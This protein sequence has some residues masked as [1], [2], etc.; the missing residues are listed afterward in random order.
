[1]QLEGKMSQIQAR[2]VHSL[3]IELADKQK[4]FI[5]IV[6]KDFAEC[7]MPSLQQQKEKKDSHLLY[8]RI[9]Q[10][11]G[12]LKRQLVDEQ[13][14]R[15]AAVEMSAQT[16]KTQQELDEQQA[17]EYLSEVQSMR[18]KLAQEREERK[19]QDDMTRERIHQAA[20]LLQ[21]ALMSSLGDETEQ[22][23]SML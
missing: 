23:N 20:I 3:H 4:E 21:S 15:K 13:V 1:M 7:I 18:Q 14:A 6:Q 2:M 11:A 22:D 9:E 8:K 5:A 19:R 12:M 10:V 17:L 16:I